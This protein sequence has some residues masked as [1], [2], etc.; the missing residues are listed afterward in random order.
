MVSKMSVSC[1]CLQIIVSLHGDKKA[2][3]TI[4]KNLICYAKNEKFK[5]KKYYDK[6]QYCVEGY[7]VLTLFVSL[8]FSVG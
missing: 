6:S 1:H 4:D 5:K 2:E 8:S 3:T 7:I